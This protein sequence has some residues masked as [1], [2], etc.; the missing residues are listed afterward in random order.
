MTD[1]KYQGWTNHETWAL[2]LWLTNEEG[3]YHYIQ[4][5]I[6][7]APN[8]YEAEERL[9]NIV[10][11]WHDDCFEDEK[12]YSS[13]TKEMKMMFREVGSLWRVNYKEIVEAF[14]EE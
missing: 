13:C 8:K 5:A 1:E 3:I 14:L 4:G 2:N 6:K 12:G 10:E 7:E 11:D 9:K